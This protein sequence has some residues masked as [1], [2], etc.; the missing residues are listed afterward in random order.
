MASQPHMLRPRAGTY[1]RYT[2]K[3]H[4]AAFLATMLVIA[5]AA[6]GATIVSSRAPS[7]PLLDNTTMSAMREMASTRPPE[8]VPVAQAGGLQLMLPVYSG[9][10]TAIGYHAANSPDAVTLAPTGH[11]ANGSFIS[12]GIDFLFPQGGFQYVTMGDGNGFGPATQA[13]DLGAP[14][15]TRVYAPVNGVIAGIRS[16]AID[17]H[18]PDV[19]IKVRPQSDATMLV[20]LTHIDQPQVTLGQ[21][22]RAGVTKLGAVR[23]LDGCVDQPLKRYTSDNGN[24]LQMQVD[25][26]R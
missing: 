2:Y 4:S 13:M 25:V 12:R 18:C 7:T 22:I 1:R 17:G 20:V 15:G 24:H 16:Y 23:G 14:A 10:I 19:E 26:V 6:L 21:P 3:W 9:E 11:Q 5:M 8:K